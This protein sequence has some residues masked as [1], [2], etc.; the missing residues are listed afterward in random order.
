MASR[1]ALWRRQAMTVIKA[2]EDSSRKLLLQRPAGLQS[3]KLGTAIHPQIFLPASFDT[4]FRHSM[5]EA[6]SAICRRAFRMAF[7]VQS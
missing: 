5:V 2:L 1:R 7:E 6:G 4:Y 3:C